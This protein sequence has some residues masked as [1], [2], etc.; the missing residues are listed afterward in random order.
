MIKT[1]HFTQ[2]Y[3]KKTNHKHLLLLQ[4]FLKHHPSLTSLIT[5]HSVMPELLPVS[6]NCQSQHNVNNNLKIK[7]ITHHSVM[8][9]LLPVRKDQ[10]YHNTN[11]SAIY[12]IMITAIQIYQQYIRSTLPQYQYISNMSDQHY[13]S[14]NI[15]AIY[16]ITITTISIYHQYIR[17][18]VPQYQYMYQQYIRSTFPQY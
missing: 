8:P 3:D 2:N 12:E 9:E 18:S 5:H 10:H 4:G 11:M 7:N 17:S 15:L 16:Q 6:T 14:T 1:N 13:Q